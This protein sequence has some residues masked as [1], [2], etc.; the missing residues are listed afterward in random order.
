MQQSI[1]ISYSAV[2]SKRFGCKILRGSIYKLDCDALK[3]LIISEEPDVIVLRLP[4][5]VKQTHYQLTTIGFPVLHCDTLVVYQCAL[6]SIQ[7]VALRNNLAFNLVTKKTEAVITSLVTEI[8]QDYNNHYSSNPFFNKDAILQGYI[9]WA[10]SFINEIDNTKYAWY[11]T[12]NDTIIAFALCSTDNTNGCEGVLYGVKKEYAGKGVY[13]DIIRFTQNY[14]KTNGLKVMKVSTQIQ[15]HSVQKAWVKEGFV[16]K[17][18]F[19]TYHI[20]CF[21]SKNKI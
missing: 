5:E 10:H 14:F 15:N 20:N 11:V 16:L 2:E 21:I 13:S 1:A 9:E 12:F 3:S 8:F 6:S 18:S 17:Q 4:S 7:S 19:D